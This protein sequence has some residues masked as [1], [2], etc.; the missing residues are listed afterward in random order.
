[1]SCPQGGEGARDNAICSQSAAASA[2]VVEWILSGANPTVPKLFKLTAAVSSICAIVDAL[3]EVFAHHPNAKC[4][5]TLANSF[6]SLDMIGNDDSASGATRQGVWRRRGRVVGMAGDGVLPITRL[7]LAS[8]QPLGVVVS[9]NGGVL[10]AQDAADL[11]ALGASSIQICTA[12]TALGVEYVEH[13]KSSLS[14]LLRYHGFASAQAL[15]GA[16][17]RNGP[18]VTPFLQLSATKRISTLIDERACI[19]CGNCKRC[20]YGA[21]TL[22]IENGG[23][24]VIDPARCVG[25]S[26]CVLQC[27]ASALTMRDR[28]PDETL[29]SEQFQKRLGVV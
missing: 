26:F 10:D 11:M 27:P 3:L 6:P 23:F 14:H 1:L 17:M 29:A 8:V 25:C 18:N 28:S 19:R 24:P 2:A 12:A 5:I 7:A 9:G 20:P 22:D 16:T 4:G 21:I 15:I 13:L